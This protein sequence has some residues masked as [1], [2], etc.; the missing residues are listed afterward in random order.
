MSKL[1]T[2]LNY[3][4]TENKKLEIEA[5][6]RGS[7]AYRE[8]SKLHNTLKASQAAIQKM[9][10]EL[11]KSTQLAQKLAE[12]MEG[13]IERKELEEEDWSIIREDEE[14]TSEE[15]SELFGDMDKV[16]KEMSALTRE[17]KRLFAEIDKAAAE[18]QKTGSEYKRD[19]ARYDELK[20]VVEGERAEANEKLAAVDAEL[21]KIEKGA[22]AE[23][24]AKYK[25]A[26]VHFPD[27]LVPVEGEKCGGC[28]MSIPMAALKKLEMPDA[29]I[30]CE[31]CGRVIYKP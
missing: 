10:E 31:N 29:T 7:D 2:V 8:L 30:E 26:H 25:K 6:L 19:K 17:I 27:A 12:R 20:T 16:S 22:D 3:Q 24:L 21:L 14:A 4:Q 18:Y 15:I 13:L 1:E 23:L 28:K 11:E 5:A 9:G